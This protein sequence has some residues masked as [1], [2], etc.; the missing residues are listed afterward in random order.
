MPRTG[1]LSW[2]EIR[3]RAIAFARAWNEERRE[4]AEAQTFWNEFFEVFGVRRRAVASFEE[5]VRSIRGTHGYIDLFWP[6]T[7]IAEHKSRG[8]PLDKAHT[9]ALGYMRSLIDGGRRHEAPRYIVV[10]DFETIALHDLEPD[11]G[12]DS[13]TDGVGG[14]SV[15]I[16]L[17]ELHEHVGLFAFIAG[18]ADRRRE[19]E[20]DVNIRAAEMLADLHDVMEAG[21]YPSH[22]L[23]RFMVRVLFCLFAEDTG[24]FGQPDAFN[25]AITDRTREDGSDLGPFLAHF[26][27]IL[28]TPPERRQAALDDTLADLPYVNGDLFAD[29]LPTAGFSREMRQHLL[30]CCRFNWGRISPAIF[31]SLFQSIMQPRQRRQIGAHYTSERDILKLLDSLFLDDLRAKFEQAR[32][33]RKAALKRFHAELGEVRVLDPA[34]GCGNFLVVAYRELRLLE[35]EVLKALHPRDRQAPLFDVRQELVVDVDRFYGIELEEWPARI[36]EVAMWLMDHQMNLLVS[37]EFGQYVARLPLERSALIRQANALRIDWNDVLPAERC[38]FVLGNP[39]FVGAKFMN[40]GQREDVRAVRGKTPGAGLLDY[41]ACWHRTAAKYLRE[42]GGRAAFVSTNSITQ[43]EQAGALWPELFRLGVVIDFAHRTFPWTSEA[44]GKA[45]VHVVIIGFGLGEPT[46]VKRIHSYGPRGEHLGVAEVRN[47]IPYLAEGPSAAVTN[48]STPLCDAPS[49][50]FGNQPIDGGHLI[51][52]AEE[53]QTLLDRCF[54]A[55]EFVR[56]Y[57]GAKEFLNGTPRW[58]LWLTDAE[59]DRLRAMPAV[60]ERIESVRKF[61]LS[62]KRKATQE[63]AS[64][65]SRFAFISHRES[66]YL[67]L[68]S[69]SSERRPYIPI[70]F[71]SRHKIASNLGLIVP[72]A[73]LYHFG[74]LH[75]AMHMA[76]VRRVCGRLESRYR[77]S[78]SLV[79]NNFPWPGEVSV[80]GRGRVESAARAVLE[81]RAAHPGATPADLYDPRTMP[82]ELQRAHAALDRAVDGLYRRGAFGDDEAR[83]E[84]LFGLWERL[85]AP[86]LAGKKRGAPRRRGVGKDRAERW[87]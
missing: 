84:H 44:R 71:V 1:P 63:L 36:A 85:S 83:F 21:G 30:R 25:A 45:H 52:D 43:G 14:G 61:R 86:M 38:S 74:V 82:R 12:G 41:V 49:M 10:S 16:P 72:G 47:I 62:S 23:E 55:E 51:L 58:C 42:A 22:D 8:E 69:V 81:A 32:R 33:R 19:P 40:A 26:F 68:P 20:D 64:N 6:G 17:A 46:G 54:E 77:Y 35:I 39:P 15:T 31:G 53:R 73:T 5:P 67:Y 11:A 59:P 79:Y 18:Y 2:N 57:F 60:L 3:R 7:L 28:N 24:L 34:C 4:R 65:P 66:D 87:R 80:A 75:S 56:P 37:R 70:G 76:W 9:Q 13:D 27:E 78:I 29:A 50:L 48:R